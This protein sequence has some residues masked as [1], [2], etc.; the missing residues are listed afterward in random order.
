MDETKGIFK[1]EEKKIINHILLLTIVISFF[2][3]IIFIIF[4]SLISGIYILFGGWFALL[5]FI[6]LKYIAFGIVEK[7][8]VWRI[9]FMYIARIALIGLVFYAIIYFSKFNFVYF[10]IGFSAFIASIMI[11]AIGQF[12]RLKWK[13]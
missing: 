6:W 1:L 3:S 7:K 10:F 8:G 13:D 9:V 4:N 2:L 5:L 12:F 11:E